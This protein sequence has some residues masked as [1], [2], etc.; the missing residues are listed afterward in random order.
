MPGDT[1]GNEVPQ[2][3]ATFIARKWAIPRSE[4]ERMLKNQEEYDGD[5]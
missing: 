4:A 5:A 1:S 2:E 3:Q